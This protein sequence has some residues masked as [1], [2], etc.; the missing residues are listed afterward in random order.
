[1]HEPGPQAHTPQ[2][3][4]AHL[5]LGALLVLLREV[6]RH[7]LREP[8]SVVLRIRLHDSVPGADIVQEEIAVGMESDR[9]E[10]R[11]DDERASIDPR[12]RGRSFQRSD[13]AGSTA[14]LIE[15]LRTPLCR[16]CGCQLLVSRRRFQ[17]PHEP[18]QSIDIEQSVRTLS[19][20]GLG[21]SV[22]QPGDLV[23]LQR[24]GD[25]DLIQIGIADE[26]QQAGVLILPAETPD[27]HLS[28]RLCDRYLNDL[29]TDPSARGFALLLR[30]IDKSLIRD[31]LDECITE[32]THA[33]ASGA[34]GLGI[35]DSLLNFR[36][37]E[38]AVRTDGAVVYKGAAGYD[39]SA[40]RNRNLGT[41]EVPIMAQVT[42]A[43]LG[44]LARSARN[45]ILMA[46]AAR[47]RVVERSETVRDL[48]DCVKFRQ[49]RL[50]RRLVDHTI[51][52]VVEAR[53]CFH[54]R[55]RSGSGSRRHGESK[56]ET[57]NRQKDHSIHRFFSS[58][59]RRGREAELPDTFVAGGPC[60]RPTASAGIIVPREPCGFMGTV[61]VAQPRGRLAW[62]RNRWIS[63]RA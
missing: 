36:T 51:S 31:R 23:R 14:D 2:R 45:G 4:R 47:L 30:E 25:A 38:G 41:L 61:R 35:G 33:H 26:R 6:A 7:L 10:S 59:I 46:L 53:G 20:V 18:G 28:R 39:L 49:I 13:M 57:Q 24:I 63:V 29:A 58:G 40:V 8:A 19:V 32:Q 22:A 44:H 1:M 3:S 50:V 52:A 9:A 12:P 48:L 37:G 43:Y 27:T 11:W 34:D 16:S 56:G 55:S 17:C 15:E 54:D 5:V 62:D 21:Y 60:L 42:D